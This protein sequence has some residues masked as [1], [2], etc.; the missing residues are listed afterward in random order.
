MTADNKIAL[1]A[2]HSQEIGEIVQVITAI[3]QQTNLLALNA[4]IEAAQAGESGKG[5]AVVAGKVG[6][7]PVKQLFR[8][9]IIHKVGP[10]QTS[11]RETALAITEISQI[12]HKIHDFTKNHYVTG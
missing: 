1:L 10:I 9:D 3:A 12:I 5:F 8:Q 7:S 2:S 4:S 6:N 11:S